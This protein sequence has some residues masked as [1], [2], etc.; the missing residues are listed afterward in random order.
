M[1]GHSEDW[2]QKQLIQWAKQFP[3][4]QFLFHIPNETTGG[5]GWIVRNSQMGC[6]KGVPDLMLPIPMNGYN[7]LFIEMKR[8]GGRLEYI[9][10]RWLAALSEFGYL[11]VCCKGW[12]EA[13]DVLQGYMEKAHPAGKADG[14]QAADRCQG[15]KGC[16][17]DIQP[18]D[19]RNFCGV[20]R[21]IY[22]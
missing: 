10:K 13:R 9:Q 4:G 15:D 3:W 12:E 8:P 1:E 6:R 16:Q 11:A 22:T 2:H 19:W 20:L 18:A 5:R 21:R 17:S 14:I 7:G